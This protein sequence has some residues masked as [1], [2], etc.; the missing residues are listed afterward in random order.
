[1][2]VCVCACAGGG[3]VI[4][5]RVRVCDLIKTNYEDVDWMLVAQDMVQRL[6]HCDNLNIIPCSPYAFQSVRKM[7]FKFLTAVSFSGCCV[8]TEKCLFIPTLPKGKQKQLSLFRMLLV[9]YIYSIVLFLLMV[10]QRPKRVAVLT[11]QLL[12]VIPGCYL[13]VHS[14]YRK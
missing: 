10:V 8:T 1:M 2:C 7:P 9:I 12:A 5:C 13:R 11:Q 6:Q 14:E 4:E 3:G